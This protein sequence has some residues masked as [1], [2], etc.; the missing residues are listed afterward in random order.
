MISSW[1]YDWTFDIQLEVG[2]QTRDVQLGVGLD[3]LYLVRIRT[4]HVISS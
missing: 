2:L 4:G 3:T 1:E